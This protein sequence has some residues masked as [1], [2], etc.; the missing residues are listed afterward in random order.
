MIPSFP[1]YRQLLLEKHI[2]LYLM[3]QN[4]FF[5]ACQNYQSFAKEKKT[6]TSQQKTLK[7]PFAASI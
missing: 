6:Q 1:L 5:N 4:T 3:I 7:V 2:A